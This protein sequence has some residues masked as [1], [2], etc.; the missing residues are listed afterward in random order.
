VLR[1]GLYAIAAAT[2]NGWLTGLSPVLMTFLLM[3]VSGVT[4]LEESLGASKPGYH[5]Y[6]AR[7]SA[8]FPWFP[9][10]PRWASCATPD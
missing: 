1:W 6:I 7:T 4:L 3:R 10:V 9:R 5:A 2:P 8:F